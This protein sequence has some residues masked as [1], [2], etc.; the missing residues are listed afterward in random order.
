MTRKLLE[1]RAGLAA[2]TDLAW[3][4][5]GS[6]SPGHSLAQRPCEAN[7]EQ[8]TGR[9]R[10]SSKRAKSPDWIVGMW[11]VRSGRELRDHAPPST[12]IILLLGELRLTRL[13]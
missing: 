2:D 7:P 9:T 8:R 11:M 10:V 13:Q 12:L 3:E 6:Q 1:H 5:G 4:S